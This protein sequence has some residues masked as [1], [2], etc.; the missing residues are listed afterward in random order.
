MHCSRFLYNY[1]KADVDHFCEVFESHTLA[2]YLQWWYW[3]TFVNVERLIFVL[4]ILP[5]L[6]YNGRSPRLNI[7]S[8]DTV[9]LI[10]MKRRLYNR[11]I[12]SPSD[13]IKSKYKQISNLVWSKTRQNTESHISS[14]SNKYF[15][16][17]KPFWRWLYSNRSPIPPSLRNS[18][19]VTVYSQKAETLNAYFSSV[20]KSFNF[21]FIHYW[22]Y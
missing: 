1:K 20:F 2:L 8:L 10:K 7:D 22:L 3:W 6:R 9:H 21:S 15:D 18:D 16:S 17:P 19:N 12:K 14:L 4:L 13:D 11:M 5:F